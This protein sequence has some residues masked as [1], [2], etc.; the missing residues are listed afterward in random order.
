[1][2]WILSST[3]IVSTSPGRNSSLPG[4]L[5]QTHLPRSLVVQRRFVSAGV[6]V[7]MHHFDVREGFHELVVV[8]PENESPQKNQRVS[9][10]VFTRTVVTVMFSKRCQLPKFPLHQMYGVY[11]FPFLVRNI[12]PVISISGPRTV[13]LGPGTAGLP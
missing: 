4:P 11:S 9:S 12:V 8:H 2:I 6:T 13:I 5:M 7:Q 3:W 10:R 1:M